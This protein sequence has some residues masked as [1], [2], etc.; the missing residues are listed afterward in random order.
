MVK[1]M[2]G[3][4]KGLQNQLRKLSSN[5]AKSQK[6]QT[7]CNKSTI[8]KCIVYFTEVRNDFNPCNSNNVNNSVTLH[9]LSIV[10]IDSTYDSNGFAHPIDIGYKNKENLLN[11]N[12]F[13]KSLNKMMDPDNEM[14]YYSRLLGKFINVFL[15][16]S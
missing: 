8:E 2:I 7:D 14:L 3:H 9:Q 11:E 10:P 15:Q 1:S 6:N 16:L 5:V 12:F 13:M 4:G